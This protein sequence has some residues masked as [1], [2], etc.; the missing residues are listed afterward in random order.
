M[1]YS[2]FNS[3]SSSRGVASTSGLSSVPVGVSGGEDRDIGTESI[4]L[5]SL[6]LTDNARSQPFGRDYTDC[7]VTDSH[8]PSPG[9]PVAVSGAS[10]TVG[11]RRRRDTHS[12]AGNARGRCLPGVWWLARRDLC[13]EPVVLDVDR[14]CF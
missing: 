12:I 7:P 11:R 3:A 9:S 13:R 14:D 4:V 1:A 8:A 6:N 10:E 2:S 5:I